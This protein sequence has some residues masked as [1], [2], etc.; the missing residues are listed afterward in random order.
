MSYENLRGK[1]YINLV[2]CS[3]DK[4]T[5]TS[6]PSQLKLLNAFAQQHGMIHAADVV[7]EGVTGSIPGARDDIQKLIERKQRKDDFEI[8]LVQDA[9]RLTR[10]GAEHGMKIQYDLK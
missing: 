5:D 4:Q 7:L 3:T 9:S 6:I 1:R 8:L 10:G 2:R